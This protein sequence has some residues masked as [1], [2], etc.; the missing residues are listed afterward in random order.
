MPITEWYLN[1][2]QLPKFDKTTID[3]LDGLKPHQAIHWNLQTNKMKNYKANLLKQLV[4]IQED[5]CA[6]CGLSLLRN[7][8]DREHFVHKEQDGGWPEFMFT[9]E[10]LFAACAYCNRALKGTAEVITHYSANYAECQFNLIHPYFD[11]PSNDLTFLLNN[12][13]EAILVQSLTQKGHDTMLFFDLHTPIMTARRAAYLLEVE[14][15]TQLA[16]ND[17]AELKAISHYKPD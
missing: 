1:I 11:T 7:L 8:V 14:R 4:E 9:S 17:Y 15:S 5:R 10:N 13:G 12:Q 6:Y 16:A 2:T 3:Y